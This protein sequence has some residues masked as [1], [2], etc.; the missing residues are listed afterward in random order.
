M[1]QSKAHPGSVS[2]DISARD[3]S[4]LHVVLVQDP[5]AK[6]FTE[7]S[8]L[9]FEERTSYGLRPLVAY[10]VRNFVQADRSKDFGLHDG[11]PE[12]R[13]DTGW[14]THLADW[15]EMMTES[16]HDFWGAES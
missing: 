12:L 11:I 14:M 4:L 7:D 10:R 1:S 16:S 13:I 3:G 9:E 6:A 5:T 15:I 2:I 8:R